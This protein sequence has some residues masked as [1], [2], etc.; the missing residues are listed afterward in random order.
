MS[1]LPVT[2]GD[3]DVAF[4]CVVAFVI[5][6]LG[7]VYHLRQEDKREGYPLLSLRGGSKPRVALMEGF[8]PLPRPKTFHLPHGHGTVTVPRRDPP[9]HLRNVEGRPV[10][11]T[12]LDATNPLDVGIGPAAWQPD[13][14]TYPDLTFEGDPKIISLNAH[15]AY[16]I[17]SGDPDPRGLLLYGLDREPVGRIVD[18]WFNQAEYDARY[19]SYAI[20]GR[21]GQFL[22]P[23]FLCVLDMKNKMARVNTL[24]ARQLRN[25]PVRA[26]EVISW[27]D[28]DRV[29]AYFAG[30]VLYKGEG[31]DA[32]A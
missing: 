29:N 16:Y 27:R 18:I 22:A 23:V 8:P 21:I 11:G 4:L 12:P 13:K 5:F 32:R 26:G 15:P 6:F 30:G 28:E 2:L 24:T 7:L 1:D 17:N 25:N 14:P 3:I 9:E 10:Y 19:F 31:D 20:D